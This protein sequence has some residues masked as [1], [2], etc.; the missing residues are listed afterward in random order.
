MQ[1]RHRWTP[2]KRWFKTFLAIYTYIYIMHK[3]CGSIRPKFSNLTRLIFFFWLYFQQKR[4]PKIYLF[5]YQYKHLFVDSCRQMLMYY[6]VRQRLVHV[7]RIEVNSVSKDLVHFKIIWIY[8]Y[9]WMWI[10]AHMDSRSPLT[11]GRFMKEF[12]ICHFDVSIEFDKIESFPKWKRRMNFVIETLMML[13]EY[14]RF[15]MRSPSVHQWTVI[16]S[17]TFLLSF[18]NH[19][20][21]CISII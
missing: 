2:H 19:I 7:V 4:V 12:V 3:P 8:E 15:H 17:G 21:H 11:S 6:S 13:F 16:S 5:F 20:E 18:G 1:I 14:F 9:M 10:Y